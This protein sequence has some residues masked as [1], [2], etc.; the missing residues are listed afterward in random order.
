MIV[1][2]ESDLRCVD[3]GAGCGLMLRP[4]LGLGVRH[5]E[6][7]QPLQRQ[8]VAAGLPEVGQDVLQHQV[9]C[10][11]S[12]RRPAHTRHANDVR[13]LPVYSQRQHR[14]IDK[15]KPPFS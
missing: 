12:C 6:A 1:A 10:R 13:L 4:D 7:V 11:V 15:C 5:K 8:A 9:G 2:Q 14:P 3:M